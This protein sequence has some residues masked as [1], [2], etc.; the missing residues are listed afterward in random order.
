MRTYFL[1]P[2]EGQYMIISMEKT[3]SITGNFYEDAVHIQIKTI[4]VHSTIT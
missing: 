1:Q 3:I 2:S 4:I